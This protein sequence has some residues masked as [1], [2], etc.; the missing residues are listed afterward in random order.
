[1][2]EKTYI[3]SGGKV[4]Y[5][6]Q[7]EGTRRQNRKKS[8]SRGSRLESRL[9]QVGNKFVVRDRYRSYGSFATLEEARARRDEIFGATSSSNT[10]TET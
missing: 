9:Y 5:Y 1:M 8:G 3:T 4:R 2:S 6:S 7:H 10:E